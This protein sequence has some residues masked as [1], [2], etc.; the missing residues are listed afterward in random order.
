MPP[1]LFFDFEVHCTS[2]LSIIFG[3]PNKQWLIV[4][5]AHIIEGGLYI[6][7]KSILL[8]HFVSIHYM[9]M[10]IKHEFSS[11]FF[12]K[13]SGFIHINLPELSNDK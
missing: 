7:T 6:S 10:I 2:H 9:F 1:H 11:Q 12:W 13:D 3:T 4:T 5:C 8:C